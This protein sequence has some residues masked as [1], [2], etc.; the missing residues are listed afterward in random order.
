MARQARTA[1]QPDLIQPIPE[2]PAPAGPAPFTP[3]GQPV[4]PPPFTPPTEAAALMPMPA[5]GP[6]MITPAAP[7][8]MAMIE[9]LAT[10]IDVEK[11]E[12]LIELQRSILDHNAKSEFEAA[13]ASMQGELPAISEKGR[14]VVEGKER[15]T[16]AKYED[17]I[18]AVRPV[19]KAHGFSLRHKNEDVLDDGRRKIKT[20]A[21]L[22]HRGGHSEH[23][24]FTFEP[25]ASG[26]MNDIQRIGSTRSYGQ[27]YTTISIL[28]IVTYGAD[29]DGQAAGAKPTP[30]VASPKGF[31]SWI[32]DLESA[33]EEG[34]AALK[35]AWEASKEEFRLH[36]QRTDRQ[37]WEKLR[38]KARE[39]KTK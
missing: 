5:Y 21:I 34:W 28:N 24:E 2:A 3:P 19:L 39:L 11:L 1:T 32:I 17:I 29:D 15:S 31:E 4:K 33:G 8:V 14:I 37:R 27:R 35:A 30:E 20:T 38:N 7:D 18:R 16:Y 13:F 12:K 25:D 9:R 26:K 23:D 10:Q 22:S 6:P 36:L